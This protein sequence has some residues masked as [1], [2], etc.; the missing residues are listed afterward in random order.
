MHTLSLGY[1]D[2]A[3][4]HRHA[5]GGSAAKPHPGTRMRGAAAQHSKLFR[6]DYSCGFQE[7]FDAVARHE[8]SCLLRPAQHSK[9]FQCDYKCGFQGNFAAV[10]DHERS[11]PLK[12]PSDSEFSLKS[13]Q[14]TM[15]TDE[16]SDPSTNV[17]A[18]QLP[19]AS[20]MTPI[21]SAEGSCDPES[22]LSSP[23]HPIHGH[24]A[25]RDTL[26]QWTAYLRPSSDPIVFLN[27]HIVEYFMWTVAY[28]LP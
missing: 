24:S 5:F 14:A 16:G 9:L 20:L 26:A 27:T 21:Y 19:I 6:C 2:V 23:P 12:P 8:R 3:Q 17:E 13:P 4:G 22:K 11:C 18:S 1:Y 10:P 7:H 25:L 15:D 28:M